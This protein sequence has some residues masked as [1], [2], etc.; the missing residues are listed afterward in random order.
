MND[1]PVPTLVHQ[2]WKTREVPV[3]FRAPCASWR[4]HHPTWSYRLWADEDLSAF[5]QAEYPSLWPLYR[6][7][8][9]DIQR[10]DAAR[11]MIL[12]RLGG[13]YAD[14]DVECLHPF[15]EL[16]S[17]ELTLPV[18]APLG[19]SNDLMLGRPGHPFFAFLLERL[20]SA[21]MRWQRPWLPRHFQVL[22]TT[23]PLFLTAGVRAWHDRTGIHLLA[24]ELY[25]SQDRER[26]WVY[27]HP[28]DTWAG[29]DTRA[30]GFLYRNWRALAAGGALVA[31]AIWL[32]WFR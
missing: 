19:Y 15:D 27:H 11:Y 25:S 3:R 17:H 12:H 7:Y 23:G 22:L 1:P 29:G 21:F 10:V 24:P 20:E 8:P 9:H 13:L 16:R 30:L 6:R 32:A 26:A 5:V 18:T 2:T 31:G 4:R 28:G 14:L